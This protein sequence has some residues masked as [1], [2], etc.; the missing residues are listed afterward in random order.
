MQRFIWSFSLTL[1][2]VCCIAVLPSGAAVT[3]TSDDSKF[4]SDVMNEGIPLLYGI[5]AVLN[6]S[7]FH[8]DNTAIGT[9]GQEQSA[10][11]DLFVTKINGYTL[12][13]EVKK[14]RD[15]YLASAEIY[16]TDL[17]EFSTLINTCGSC[18]SKIN[19]MYPKMNDE[20]KKTDKVIIQFYQTSQ[21]PI[22]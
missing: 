21:A 5:P 9:V 14:V 19:E 8:G 16:K 15:Q 22:S 10:A 12:S 2:L 11:L 18:I 6:A 13:D 4:L 20:A 3:I 7:F 17:T 1:V